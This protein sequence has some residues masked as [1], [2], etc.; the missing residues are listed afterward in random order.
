MS[1]GRYFKKNGSMVCITQDEGEPDEQFIDRGEFVVS[2]APSNDEDYETAVRLSRI[3]RNHKY[4]RS[5]YSSTIMKQMEIM[6]EK[7][8]EE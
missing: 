4:S 6:R 5:V 7:M 3:Y 1:T 8:F 2:Q